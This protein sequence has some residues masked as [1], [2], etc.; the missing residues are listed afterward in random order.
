MA[1][2]YGANYTKAI[3]GGAD[4]IVDAGV[5]GGNVK[6]LLDTYEASSTAA[7]T[8][9]LMGKALKTHAR[10]IGV[11]LSCDALGGSTTLAIGDQEDADRYLVAKDSSSAIDGYFCAT[12]NSQGYDIDMTTSTTPDNIVAVTVGGAA[13]TGTINVAILYTEE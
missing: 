7:D 12:A 2:V 4:N 5:L 9:I 6:V 8:V 13:A 3:A 10:V 1:T 11:F